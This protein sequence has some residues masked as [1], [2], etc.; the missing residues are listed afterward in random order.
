[1][2]ETR[3]RLMDAAEHSIRQNGYNAVSFRELAD[4]LGIKSASVHYH[5]RKKE[6]LGLALVQ[7]YSASFFKALETQ[8]KSATTPAQ[9]ISAFCETYKQALISSD[10]ICL[11]G[12]LGAESVSLPDALADNV[13]DFPCRAH[14]GDPT[15]CHDAGHGH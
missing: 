15:R 7:R 12:I 8:S 5:F 1:M 13:T 14:S 11:C 6:D 4:D 3:D 10:A 2:S 9:K